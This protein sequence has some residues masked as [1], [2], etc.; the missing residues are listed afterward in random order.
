MDFLDIKY[1]G[2]RSYVQKHVDYE[3]TYDSIR[4]LEHKF[5]T[6]EQH[7][8]YLMDDNRLNE[9]EFTL[10]TWAEFVTNIE[11]TA[12]KKKDYFMS[13]DLL[14]DAIL[15]SDKNST[16]MLYKDRLKNV[17][18]FND[19]AIKSVQSSSFGIVKR[20]TKTGKGPS[21]N[22]KGLVIGD[23][24]SG[25]TSNMGGTI[26]IA[27]DNHWN[28]FIVLTGTIDNLRLQTKNR[29]VKDLM[30][31]GTLRLNYKVIEKPR[32]GSNDPEHQLDTIDLR[33]ESR[34]RILNVCL[35]NKTNLTNLINWLESNE[36][37][38]AQM[39]IVIIDDEADQASIN[40]N[41]V[42]DPEIN[43]TV[44]NGLIKKLV[45]S[46]Q[47]KSVNYIA[48]TATPYALILNEGTEES[49]YPRNFILALKPSPDYMGPKQ[50]FGLQEPT[51]NPELRVVRLVSETETDGILDFLNGKK[52]NLSDYGSLQK[53]VHWF[54]IS[55][56]ALRYRNFSKPIS[57]LIHTGMKTN[58]H[59]KMGELIKEILRGF[60]FD[61]TDSL[62]GLKQ[63]YYEETRSFDKQDFEEAMPK[64]SSEI[65]DY[66]SW[67]EITEGL[68]YLHNWELKNSSQ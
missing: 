36:D 12:E 48:Y 26:A 62:E 52:D 20:L 43:P 59:Q 24:Q 1:D 5:L 67:A 30:S 4:N 14:N 16:W 65:L 47:Y 40:T 63:L 11:S 7:L 9:D 21:G 13:G 38:A 19:D 58:S 46:T 49:L 6:P 23:V 60:Y 41:D 2:L 25:K 53:A 17:S 10:E 31:N 34:N 57:M 54:L 42:N 45:N 8:N 55:V 39:K 29:L 33:D 15:P 35:K 61:Y 50:Y 68:D 32:K 66:P 22:L 28:V 56:A 51:Q 18:G 37:K 27:A 44:I 3:A 64:Y